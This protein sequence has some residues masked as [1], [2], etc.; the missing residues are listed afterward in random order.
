MERNTAKDVQHRALK[1]LEAEFGVGTVRQAGGTIGEKLTLKFEIS[2]G[3]VAERLKLARESWERWCLVVHA[4]LKK[5]HFGK[6]FIHRGSCYTINEIS[7]SKPKYAVGCM[8][9]DGKQFGFPA[10]TIVELVSL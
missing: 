10:A 7:P 3:G 1:A 5:E 4:S 9:S 8:R 2:P 6:S